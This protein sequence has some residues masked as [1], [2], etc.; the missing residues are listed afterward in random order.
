MRQNHRLVLDLL[1]VAVLACKH[2]HL[3]LVHAQLTDVRLQQELSTNAPPMHKHANKPSGR[4]HQ[5]TAYT[6][7]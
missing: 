4:K 3:A 6:G 2:V 5:H 7:T 1:H